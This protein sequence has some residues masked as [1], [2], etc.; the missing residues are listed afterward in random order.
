MNIGAALRFTTEDK[1]WIEKIAIAAVL[2]FTVIGWLAVV[3]WMLELL[4]RVVRGEAE[5]LPPWTNLGKYFVDGLK[6]CV[7]GFIW[8]LPII[9]LSACLSGL[10][11]VLSGLQGD[12]SGGGFG[13][14]LN[15]CLAFISLPYALVVSFLYPPML[16]IYAMQGKFAEAVNPVKAWRLARANLNG[17][18]TA[19]LLSGVVG[20]AASLI[21]TILCVIGIYP[22]GAYAGA[23]G[24]H[25]YGQAYREGTASLPAA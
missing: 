22:L 13:V 15:I 2:I 11:G 16:G 1:K 9:V 25:L 17:F 6:V 14:F 8:T 5:V 12:N 19:W 20:V 10:T 4:R 21:G 23:V 3:G 7:I 24:A 18:L